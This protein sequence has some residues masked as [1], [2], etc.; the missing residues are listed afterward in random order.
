[1]KNIGILVFDQVEELDFVGPLEVF[2]LLQRM[3]PDTVKVFTVE[4][5]GKPFRGAFQLQV[6]PEYS[7]AHCPP[8]D[9]LVVPGGRGARTAMNDARVLEF[10]KTRAAQAE[11][12][13]SVCTGSL[14]LAKAGLLQG[15]RATTHRTALDELREF[16]GVTVEHLRYIHEG[17]VITSGGISAGIDMAFYVVELLCGPSVRDDVAKRMEY[18]LA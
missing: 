8:I 13:T 15:K 6:I 5:D 11:F 14:I 16:S 1:M 2:G 10:V 18:R 7:F 17:N 12:I 4:A 9:I 3:Q